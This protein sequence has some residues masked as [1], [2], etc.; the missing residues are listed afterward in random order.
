MKLHLIAVAG[1]AALASA[2]AATAANLV[3]TAVEVNASGPYAGSFD[4]LVAALGAA[5]PAILEKLSSK[6]QMTVFAPTDDAFAALNLDPTSVATALSQ[7]NLSRILM[8]HVANGR[9]PSQAVTSKSQVQTLAKMPIA[10]DGTA[11]TDEV[12]RTSNIIV[13]D[14]EAD[15]GI[16]H[17]IDGVLLPFQ[18]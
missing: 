17:V 10:V 13:P 9:L 15:N 12:G 11:L 14:V 1:A 18:P 3:D 5:D 2:P 6:G 16:I 7:E 4:T 8:Y